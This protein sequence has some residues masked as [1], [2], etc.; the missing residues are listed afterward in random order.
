MSENYEDYQAHIVDD[1]EACLDS[2]GCQPTLF[3]GSGFSKRYMNA[4]NWEELL[5][6]MVCICP[7]ITKDY[8]YYKQSHK[9]PID[10]GTVFIEPFK[11]WAWSSGK[12]DF[13]PELFS[14][15]YESD[16]Y[17]KYKVSSY[18][19]DIT[20]SSL[21]DIIDTALVNEITELK[22]INPHAIITTNYDQLLEVMFDEYVPLVGQHIL[23]ANTFSVG[24]IFKIHGCITEP[25]SLVLTRKDFDEFTAR[26]KYLSAKL[27]T[28]FAEHPLL[29]IGYS[30]SD[31][32][33]KA[34]LSDIDE[35][36]S[37]ESEL[38]PNIYILQWQDK[39][40][41]SD[42]PQREHAIVLNEYR[43]IRVKCIVAN[44]FDWVFKAF[45]N[46]KPLESIH[47]KVLRALLARTYELVRCDIPR[48]IV[49]VDFATLEHAVMTNGEIGKFFGITSI[50]DATKV[51]AQFPYALTMVASELG[52]KSW[53]NA[54]Q[55]IDKLKRETSKDIKATDNKYHI[56][57][58]AGSV[59]MT[60][61]YSQ[62]AVDL[63]EKVKNGQA[64]TL[65]V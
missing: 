39:I 40:T 55:L 19:N 14:A 31:P 58:K 48:K 59:M 10:I 54:N 41:E 13:P 53:H 57:I 23:R 64:Y 37:K 27:L 15:D 26:K 62:E 8:A 29:I 9:E 22:S 32:N 33:I 61:K 17:L 47:P 52:Y 28:F 25:S 24:E 18:I 11:E 12:G 7:N 56:A 44:N 3:V 34:I 49:E 50:G 20:P 1:I 6:K 46:N 36:I 43:N 5:Q 42:Y 21:T 2:L 38:I 65:D 45:S 16:I 4:P 30:A 60:H 63:L 51:N 35:I